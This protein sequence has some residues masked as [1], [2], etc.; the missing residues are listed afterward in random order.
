MSAR[1]ETKE[2]AGIFESQPAAAEAVRRL[3]S[4][5]FG[6]CNDLSVIVSDRQEREAVP[7]SEPIPVGKSA[8]V[9]AALG[10][11]VAGVAV[12]FTGIDFGPF[13]LV[14][15]GSLWAIFE[16]AFTGG[17]A[18]FAV[19]ALMSIEAIHQVADFSKTKMKD[20][21]VWVGVSA[22]APRAAQA[23]QILAEAGAKHLME[24][25]PEAAESYH[26]GALAA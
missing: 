20:G 9:G 15:W 11:F 22:T 2:I 8:W 24:R 25:R 16:G 26:F 3:V 6:A 7:V 5:H 21:V 17:S 19:G 14:E 13:T 4:E 18:G 23:R 12:A 10:A 1:Q